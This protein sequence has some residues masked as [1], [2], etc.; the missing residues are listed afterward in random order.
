L[1]LVE[2]TIVLVILGV[3][4]QS[5]LKGQE[6]IRSARVR[7]IMVQQAG[8]EQAVLTFQDRYRAMPADYAQADDA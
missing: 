7:D 5:V 4:I 2:V 6:L 1:T 3:V 8:V